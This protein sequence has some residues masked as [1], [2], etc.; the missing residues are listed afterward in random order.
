LEDEGGEIGR[1]GWRDWK[2][3]V[4]RL[5]DRGGDAKTGEG[6]VKTGKNTTDLKRLPHGTH[7]S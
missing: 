7:P 3:G 4:E 2:M 6:S 5:E 1:R